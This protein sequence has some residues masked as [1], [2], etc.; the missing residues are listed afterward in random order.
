MSRDIVRAYLAGEVRALQPDDDPGVPPFAPPALMR[1]VARSRRPLAPEVHRVLV[2]QNA[3]LPASPARDAHLEALRTGAAAV[4]TGQQVG[5]FLGPLYTL[6]KAASAVVF[7]RMLAARTGAPVV[8]VFWLQTEDHDLPEIA[9]VTVPGRAGA[10]TLAV[11]V[12]AGNRIAIAHCRL[13]PEIDGCLD[14]LAEALADGQAASPHA[15]AHVAR[16]RRH[17]RPGARWADAFAGVLAELFAPEGLVMIDPREPAL[18]AAVAPVHARAL[19][20]AGPIAAALVAN[21]A[22]LERAGFATAVHVRP[23][24]PLSFF[25]PAGPLGPRVRLEPVPG[26][27]GG[28]DA[29]AEVGGGAVHSRAELLAALAADPLRFS[30]SALLRPIA[31][32]TLL[33][34][35]A[36]VGGPAEVGYFAQL[37]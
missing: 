15:V 1:A 19:A 3:R 14:A 26:R 24:A 35:A 27:P 7:A 31:Q 22:E 34:T 28:D 18:A 21:D 2:A 25:H 30:T 36:Y 11:P 20:E 9:S 12:D 17:Y 16:L 23:G 29:F 37:P 10:T 8:P 32:D 5:L 6:Y 33:P 4:V 13:P